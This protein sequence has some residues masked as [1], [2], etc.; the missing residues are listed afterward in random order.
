MTVQWTVRAD[1]RSL[2]RARVAHRAGC[3]VAAKQRLTTFTGASH[4]TPHP[5]KIKDFCHLPLKGKALGADCHV[6]G[7]PRN[8]SSYL[9]LL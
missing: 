8:D 3:G 4:P 6:A 5:S 2:R 9:R 1:D 7:A